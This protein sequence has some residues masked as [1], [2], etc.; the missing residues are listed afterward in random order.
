[1]SN[2][3]PTQYIDIHGLY[4]EINFF[5]EHNDPSNSPLT[6]EQAL[7]QSVIMQAVLDTL[8]TSR[9]TSERIERGKA[10]AWF[11]LTNSNFLWVCSMAEMEPVFVVRNVCKL[12]K[13]HK[14]VSCKRRPKAKKLPVLSINTA[15][16]R[17]KEAI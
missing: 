6:G 5:N 16:L 14:Q 9:R 17:S 12:L 4:G 13:K 7:W 2:S 1:M 15:P 10:I 8:S 3:V 11:S